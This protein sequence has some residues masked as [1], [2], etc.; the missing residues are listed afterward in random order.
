VDL[1][2]SEWTES[3]RWFESAHVCLADQYYDDR[4]TLIVVIE[5]GMTV[6]HEETQV[7]L[8]AGQG[9]SI[10]RGVPFAARMH[11]KGC[12]FHVHQRK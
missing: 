4:D 9:L 8:L 12:T 10:P 7:T 2:H 6:L 5:G 1:D 3:V 11:N